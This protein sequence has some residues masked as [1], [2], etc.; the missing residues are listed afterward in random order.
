MAS[1]GRFTSGERRGLI[2]LIILMLIVVVV[3]ALSGRFRHSAT[4][5]AVDSPA[6]TVE[7]V[8]DSSAAVSRDDAQGQAKSRAKKKKR[9]TAPA[10]PP[11]PRSPLD[12]GLN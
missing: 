4:S 7:S 8:G 11:T 5:A 9:V 3:M 10:T 12:E 6:F 2:V 1:S